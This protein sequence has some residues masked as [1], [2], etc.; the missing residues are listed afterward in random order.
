MLPIEPSSLD[1]AKKELGPVSVWASVG[2][3]QD[4]RTSMLQP[5][6]LICKL[7]PV[8][9]FST[10]SIVSGEISTLAHELSNNTVEGG[11]LVAKTFL[12]CAQRSE[13]LS[14]P[15]DNTVFKCHLNPPKRS[16]VSCH[17]EV[18]NGIAGHFDA[19]TVLRKTKTAQEQCEQAKDM[20]ER[21]GGIDKRDIKPTGQ[22]FVQDCNDNA[23]RSFKFINLR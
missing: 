6:V 14:S 23:Y 22:L 8:D 15:R 11:P 12:T 4:A 9:T 5:K 13:V 21:K 19:G 10:S 20:P 1:S 17:I 2:H 18:H 16:T 3:A 7:F